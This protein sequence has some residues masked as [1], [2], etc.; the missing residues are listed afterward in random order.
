[1]QVLF[2]LGFPI[3]ADRLARRFKVIDWLGPV[4]LCYLAGIVAGNLPRVDLDHTVSDRVKDLAVP[5]AIPLLLFSLDFL[6]WLRYA[7]K[8]AFSFL[9]TLASLLIA[10]GIGA[11]IFLS[12][13][14]ECWKIA[15]M[16]VGVYTGGT[17]NLAA[18]GLALDVRR[19]TYLLVNAADVVAGGLYFLFLLTLA[20]PLLRKILPPFDVSPALPSETQPDAREADGREAENREPDAREPD[21]REPDAREPD[22]REPDAREP[23]AR[24]IGGT[25]G[26]D[27]TSGPIGPGK[28]AIHLLCGF[29]LSAAILALAVGLSFAIWREVSVALVILVIT[30]LGIA[31]SFSRRIHRLAGTFEFGNYFILVFCVA[32]GS[33]VE[34]KQLLRSGSVIFCYLTTVMLGS[35]LLHYLFSAVFRIDVDTTIITSTAAI[36]GPPFVPPVAAAIKNRE[37]LITGLTTGLIGYAIGNYLGLTVSYVLQR[38]STG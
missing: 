11:A 20:K 21:A 2:L 7:R 3:L 37:V 1:M 31:S 16:L 24:E 23:D 10:T 8:A 38:F 25:G 17:P 22:A 32:I 36:Y 26:A 4:L 27:T 28:K 13:I 12:R 34:F 15:G 33:M 30:T 9:L 19:E 14:P 5:L 18:I 29:G 6:K 35:I